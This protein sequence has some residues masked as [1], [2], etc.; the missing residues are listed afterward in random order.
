M[1]GGTP[2]SW[3]SKPQA[4]VSQSGCESEYYLLSKAG[5]KRVWLRLL[6]QELSY[7][8]IAPTVILADNQG[9]IALA[10]HP[11]FHKCTKNID[12]KFYYVQEVMERGVLLLEFLST[13][14][15][16]ADGLTKLLSSNQFQRFLAMMNMA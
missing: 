14:F 15:M 9:A 16:A 3:S 10:K 5:K 4:S 11:E 12:T 8:S 2:I 13:R 7:I 1:M 6:L